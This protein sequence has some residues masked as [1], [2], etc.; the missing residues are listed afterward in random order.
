MI[1]FN[2]YDGKLNMEEL[3]KQMKAASENQREDLPEGD[4]EVKVDKLEVRESKQG[5]LMLAVQYRILSGRYRNQCMFQ[6]IIL[7]GTRNDGFMIH[8]AKRL[9]DDMGYDIDFS[10]YAQFADDIDSIADDAVGQEYEIG[11]SYQN[12]Y[13]RFTFR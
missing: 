10:S 3:E 6:N 12:G 2:K 4:Y 5:K 11:L 7:S 13:P 1:D 8:Q 9:I